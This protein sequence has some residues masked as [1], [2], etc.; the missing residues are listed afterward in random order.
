VIR[1]EWGASILDFRFTAEDTIREL[2]FALRWHR[3]KASPPFALQNATGFL[4][5]GELLPVVGS[6]LIQL[7]EL[8][9]FQSNEES[10]FL[11]IQADGTLMNAAT[12]LA[13]HFKIPQKQIVFLMNGSMIADLSTRIWLYENSI[14]FSYCKSFRAFMFNGQHLD[15]FVDWDVPLCDLSFIT[16]PQ[17]QYFC[18]NF[19]LSLQF[20]D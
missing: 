2:H 9:Q 12:A 6:S 1:V 19:D 18:T 7:A 17:I 11:A 5:D 14:D 13:E 4:T 10:V 16:E 3:G 8:F 15:L 20:P